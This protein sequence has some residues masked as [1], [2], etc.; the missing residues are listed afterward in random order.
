MADKYE[1]GYLLTVKDLCEYLEAEG[2]LSIRIRVNG[3]VH[4]I[5]K[6]VFCIED[7]TIIINASN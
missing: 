1:E 2:D 7:N 4:R 5:E 6:A 3:N